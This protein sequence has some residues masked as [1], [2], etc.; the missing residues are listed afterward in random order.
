MLLGALLGVLTLVTSIP[1]AAQATAPKVELTGEYS[2]LRFNP[3]LPGIHNRNFNGG[4]ADASFFFKPS[5]GIKA[6]VQFY[7]STNF[8]AT[9]PATVTSAGKIPA[10]SYSSNGNLR[11]FLFGPIIKAR[12][13]HFEPF[14]QVLFGVAQVNA[15]SNLSRVIAGAPGSTLKVQASQTPFSM[16]AGGGIDVPVSKLIAVRVADI[17]Y[18]LTRLT[19]PLTSTNNQNHFRYAAGLQF[20]FGS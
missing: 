2:Y 9:F 20:R 7:G 4:G 6:D 10:G 18:V 13:K 1:A 16:A 14:G 3:T 17:D 5:I 19:N 15:Y 11:T 12:F 8:N